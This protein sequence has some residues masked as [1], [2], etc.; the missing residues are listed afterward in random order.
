MCMRT[1][2]CYGTTLTFLTELYKKAM[3]QTP[4]NTS[5]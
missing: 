5:A 1:Y 4:M 3:R 2:L